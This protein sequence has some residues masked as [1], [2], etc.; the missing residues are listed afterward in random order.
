MAGYCGYS[1]S[2]NAVDAYNDG[3]K[4]LSKW[5]KRAIIEAIEEAVECEDLQLQCDI[6]K[7]KQCKIDVFEAV[8]FEVVILAPH[9]QIL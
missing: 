1:M 3:E 5:T 6:E 2:N 8:V 9:K 7:L 4:P